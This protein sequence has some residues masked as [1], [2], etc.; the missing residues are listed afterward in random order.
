ME[1]YRYKAVNAQG[2]VLQGRI[3]AVNPADLE[4]RLS[5][6]G[7]DLVNY[8][9][10]KRH[11]HVT[12]RGIQRVDLI[13]FCFHLEHLVRAGVPILEGLADLRDTIDNKRLREV[14]GAMIE[15]IEG[16]KN[17]SQSMLDFP[18]VFP[19]VFVSLIRA[20]EESGQLN[21]VLSK[22][23]ENLK[24]QD[25]QAAITKKLLLYPAIV[26]VVVIAVMFFLMLYV[27]PQLI[28]FLAT[29]GQELPLQTQALIATSAFMTRYWYLVMFGPVLAL[30][31]LVATYRA[32]P[33]FA[34]RVDE[35]VLRLPLL[36]P[37][38]KKL[39]VTRVCQV[40]SIMYSSGITVLE[41]IRNAEAVAGNR[42]VSR[43]MREA[44]RQIADGGGISRSFAAT[45]L[46]PPLV[47]RMLRVGEN[48][49]ALEEALDNVSYFYARD[50]SESVARLQAMIMPAITMV[51]G[52]LLF[53][54]MASVLGP[55]YDLFTQ[56]DF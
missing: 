11:K 5:R 7:L 25:E 13:T 28:S 15:S 18:A 51:L 2:R 45:N 40:F 3:D 9:E 41:C 52:A 26:T 53:W 17:L 48:T 33:K 24:W 39:I 49:G 16:G 14:T 10:L 6:L 56:I 31:G 8:R 47:I 21:L 1:A 30:V 20:G 46:F 36:G 12:G 37:V 50:V 22:I 55:I 32:N 34:E 44:G 38:M 54:I 29:M 23:I 4:T 27:V 43:A 35:W 19:A 42:A